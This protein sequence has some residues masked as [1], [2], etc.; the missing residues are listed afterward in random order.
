MPV[1]TASETTPVSCLADRLLTV[2]RNSRWE[3]V[4]ELPLNFSTYH[5][6]G[7]AFAKGLTFL[8][9][10]QIL[11]EPRPARNPAL[12]TAGRGT[13]HMFVL[14]Q[15][16]ELIRDITLG[17]GSI[18][19]P[20]GIDFDGENLWVSVAEYRASSRSIVYTIDPLSHTAREQFRINDHIGWIV[21]DPQS[22]LLFGGSWGSRHL[23]TWDRA[24]RVL[25]CWEN[26]SHFIDYQDAQIAGPGILLC[27]GISLLPRPGCDPFELGGL[28]LLDHTQH[29]II[30]DTPISLFSD[31][32]HVIT[33]NPVTFTTD[34]AELLLHTAP[35]D[36]HDHGGTRI[37]TYRQVPAQRYPT[38]EGEYAVPMR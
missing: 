18:Y 3:K 21:R 22:G 12:R 16:G 7:M 27:S 23:Y 35:D 11:E 30:H 15:D 10:V 31:A 4:G 36:G 28:A 14:A 2:D 32:G 38:S 19:H 37:L 26:P 17:E 13:G 9:S 20:G 33:R 8:S 34:E 5:P 24:G 1:P 6:Q 25:D 29:R